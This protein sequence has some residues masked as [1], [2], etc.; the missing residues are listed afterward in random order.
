MK[1]KTDGVVSHLFDDIVVMNCFA[2]I[3]ISA[4][5]SSEQGACIALELIVS[6]WH[7]AQGTALV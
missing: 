1:I 5:G 6:H 2:L 7:R 3:I 4:A